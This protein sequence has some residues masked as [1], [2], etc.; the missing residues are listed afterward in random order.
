MYPWPWN[1]VW[2]GWSQPPHPTD[3]IPSFDPSAS[4][5]QKARL[6]LFDYFHD[7]DLRS[8]AD[9][10]AVK[11]AFGVKNKADYDTARLVSAYENPKDSV[12]SK[13]ISW[14]DLSKAV[15]SAIA[16][17]MQLGPLPGQSTYDTDPVVIYYYDNDRIK[18]IAYPKAS[19]SPEKNKAL[20]GTN[21]YWWKGNDIHT[22]ELHNG[23]WGD[24]GFDWDK[25]VAGNVGTITATIMSVVGV[26]LQVIPGIGTGVGAAIL[27]LAPLVGSL[28]GAADVA[29]QGGDMGNALGNI[30]QAILQ[31]ASKGLA[32]KA[33]IKLDKDSL[34]KLGS[35]L[36]ILAA[37]AMHLQQQGAKFTDTWNQL[38]ANASKY[39]K[40]SD[41]EIQA[42]QKSLG[43]DAAASVLRK[44]YD[45]AQ[46]A[47]PA[48]I[49][50]IT[51]LFSDRGAANLFAFGA[52][53]GLLNKAQVTAVQN[54]AKPATLSSPQGRHAM[55]GQFAV[56]ADA[57]SDFGSAMATSLAS[58]FGNV[59]TTAAQQGAKAL[60]QAVSTPTQLLAAQ[61]A[62]LGP[63]YGVAV[64]ATVLPA[65][66]VTGFIPGAVVSGN[67]M[68]G[69]SL[70]ER[71]RAG[72]TTQH[73]HLAN[74]AHASPSHMTGQ[75]VLS[76]GS[77]VPMAGWNDDG[78]IY[79][80]DPKTGH[81]ID[82]QG[83]VTSGWGPD[84]WNSPFNPPPRVG[85]LSARDWGQLAAQGYTE[86]GA[87]PLQH[88]PGAGDTAG[89][90]LVTNT[91]VGQCV[92]SDGSILAMAGWDDYGNI[93]CIDP[94]TG[95]KVNATGHVVGMLPAAPAPQTAVGF[96]S[97]T[98]WDPRFAG[99]PGY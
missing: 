87:S 39:G 94:K 3:I 83:H 63:K 79:C 78:T 95:Q 15:Q 58:A 14:S 81:K 76:D 66:K 35:S 71:F 11:S 43:S 50:A 19:I 88:Q 67:A 38:A 52:G 6:V 34:N 93:Y 13:G 72:K 57:G 44:G 29:F 60:T 80:F 22:Y 91:A 41:D 73:A 21:I 96:Q 9:N 25:D 4:P 51:G 26:V 1:P 98:W 92:M 5:Q 10:S 77:I 97:Q 17:R 30:S 23:A 37:D 32:D 75:C 42:I 59:L 86:Y 69:Q 64:P 54:A 85:D 65:V 84:P 24:E 68:T 99:A 70:A 49:E 8:W 47:T 27:A 33:G 55:T 46:Y 56:G 18:K 89:Q 82:A 16:R 74:V 53:L 62:I 36:G 40:F 48:N 90:Y 28:L 45:T 12:W 20:D 7:N 61:V 2:T 31:L